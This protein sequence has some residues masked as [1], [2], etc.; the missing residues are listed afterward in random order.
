MINSST[1][2]EISVKQVGDV[3]ASYNVKHDGEIR[4]K[5]VEE[6]TSNDYVKVNSE[7]HSTL[8]DLEEFMKQIADDAV[9]EV[10]QFNDYAHTLTQVGNIY[11]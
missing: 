4:L 6:I 5:Q 1:D 2:R 3:T 7:V 8:D 9:V 11:L 10:P